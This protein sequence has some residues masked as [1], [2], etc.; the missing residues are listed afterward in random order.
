MA[1]EVGTILVVDDDRMS[2]MMLTRVLTA[3]GHQVTAAS[4]GKAGVELLG[5]KPFDLLV[6]D[7]L[8]P[9]MDGYEVLETL[10]K[11]ERHK[12]LPIIMV[13]GVED[14][15]SVVACLELGA[16]DYLNKPFDPA[17]LRARIK[18][19]LAQKRSREREAKLYNDLQANYTKLRELESLRDNLIHMIVHDLRV[20]L[21]NVIG[22]LELVAGVQDFGKTEQEL[23]G[24][25]LRGANTLMALINDLLDVRRMETDAL[26]FEKK[27]VDMKAVIEASFAQVSVLAAE[28][29]VRLTTSIAAESVAMGDRDILTRV[30]TNLLSNAVK[31]TPAGG[32][33]TVNVK[34]L[35]E[36]KL[37]VEV[38]DTGDGIPPE[39]LGRVFDR[40]YQ[41]RSQR[42]TRL[43]ASGLG[44]TF[45][46]LAV[47]A[48]GGHIVAEST[49]GD[50]STFSFDLSRPA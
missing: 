40:F 41:V 50:G 18:N 32:E 47:E 45:C 22:A 15:A 3:S 1:E 9:E 24:L 4:S 5:S 23:V 33:V 44:L 48:H 27:A 35:N 12:D 30:V 19:A 6:L 28:E 43:S 16:N 11:D 26:T 36:Q 25:S 38:K 39:S 2:T 34:P 14:M 42:G 13:S 7:C 37:L 20:P 49:V 31:F 8:M 21:T 46:K 10:R 29:K 17:V